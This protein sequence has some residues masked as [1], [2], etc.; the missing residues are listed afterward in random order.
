MPRNQFV[1]P[2]FLDIEPRIIGPITA[3]QFVIMLV[4]VLLDFVFYR[5]FSNSI[6]FLLAT[7]LPITGIGAVFAFGKVNGQPFH[8]I[9]LNVIQ[10]W[11]RPGKR[12]WDKSLTDAD[13][14]VLMQ[15]DEMAPVVVRTRK[16][17]LEGSRLSELALVVN[18][19]GVYGGE[20]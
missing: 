12:V 14:R 8:V 18:T 4:I 3:R 16:A 20:E 6:P 7:T 2:Q 5:I 15:K 11:R 19:G 9:V 13:I 1:V 17:P 10:T